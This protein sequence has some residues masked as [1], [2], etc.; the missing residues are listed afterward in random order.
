LD[1]APKSERIT[2]GDDNEIDFSYLV[3]ANEN[4]IQIAYRFKLNVCI[5]P[6]DKYEGLRD[7]I[8][9]VYAKCQEV[10]VFKKI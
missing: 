3:Q 1:E 4:N 9:K 10:L 7:F 5:V 8:S 6:V 2:Y